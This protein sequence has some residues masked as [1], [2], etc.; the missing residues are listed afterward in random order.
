MDLFYMDGISIHVECFLEK[1]DNYLNGLFLY[2]KPFLS[3][4]FK[5]EL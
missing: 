2:E 4:Y 1:K 5:K 3:I